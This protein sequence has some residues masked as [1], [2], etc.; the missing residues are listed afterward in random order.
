MTTAQS[1][2]TRAHLSALHATAAAAARH[3]EALQTQSMTRRRRRLPTSRRQPGLV[4]GQRAAAAAPGR[5]RQLSCGEHRGD[6]QRM[7][8][9]ES[10]D[11]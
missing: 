6:A 9:R 10:K 11:I 2:A 8:F 1:R 5:A 7:S 3:H 4:R